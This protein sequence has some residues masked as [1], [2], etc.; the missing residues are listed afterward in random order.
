MSAG[1]SGA[2][3]ITIGR[4]RARVRRPCVLRGNARRARPES[5]G[6][7]PDVLREGGPPACGLRVA[8][9]RAGGLREYVLRA[10]DLRE[11]DRLV[12]ILRAEGLRVAVLREADP[13]AAGRRADSGR[14]ARANKLR[15]C[16]Y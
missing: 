10:A 14:R 1:A 4:R 5:V 2:S 9:R 16:T 7:L 13:R 11:E 6:R 12:S 3:R 8:V 15:M